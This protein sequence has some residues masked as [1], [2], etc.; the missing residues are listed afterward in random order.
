VA[1]TLFCAP[2]RSLASLA[3]RHMP[4]R[5]VIGRR[6]T[7]M[8]ASEVPAPDF[9]MIVQT[10]LARSHH[11]RAGILITR[12]RFPVIPQGPR[13]ASHVSAAWVRRGR[14]LV[15]PRGKHAV[16]RHR[17][18]DTCQRPGGSGA[19]RLSVELTGVWIELLRAATGV[20]NQSF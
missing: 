8:F 1:Q 5:L 13:T 4:S 17:R 6:S 3:D 18:L 20:V 15:G 11:D 14:P 12:R 9:P 19:V 7:S 16:F 2:A 10:K